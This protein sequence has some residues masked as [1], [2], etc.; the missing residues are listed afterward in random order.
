METVEIIEPIATVVASIVTAI[1]ILLGGFYAVFKLRVFRDLKPHLTITQRVSHRS[2]GTK[3][4]HVAVTASLHNSSKVAIAIRRSFSRLQTISPLADA[5][6]E[7]LYYDAFSDDDDVSIWW[8]TLEEIEH[9]WDEGE[10]IV[11]PSESHSETYE[12]IIGADIETILVYTYFYNPGYETDGN[13]AEG[14]HTTTVYDIK[15]KIGS[16]A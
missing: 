2:I 9:P 7:Q 8:P 10:L 1:A 11:E 6:I 15:Q 5:D 4:V 14:W 13:V 16:V 3:Y 12:F